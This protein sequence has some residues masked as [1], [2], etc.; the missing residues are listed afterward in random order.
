MTSR[1]LYFLL[2]SHAQTY[3]K[4]HAKIITMSW[5]Y[6]Y[7]IIFHKFIVL[8]FLCFWLRL[9]LCLYFCLL[10]VSLSLAQPLFLFLFIFLSLS[11][12]VPLSLSAFLCFFVSLFFNV[13]HTHT[14][15]MHMVYLG[16]CVSVCECFTRLDSAASFILY[17]LFSSFITR[18][19]DSVRHTHRLSSWLERFESG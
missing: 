11:F 14:K 7:A 4:V 1:Y 18:G 8:L 19:W 6:R 5:L 13:S 10:S 15:A 9:S 16:L 2:L 3:K 12:S 17:Q